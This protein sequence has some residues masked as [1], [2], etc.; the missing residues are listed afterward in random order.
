MLT[1]AGAFTKGVLPRLGP[2]LDG[3]DV[4]REGL[5]TLVIVPGSFDMV[6]TL[7][8]GS[9]SNCIRLDFIGDLAGAIL[10]AAALLAITDSC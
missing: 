5:G 9:L 1:V 6:G 10:S 3:D 8:G 4:G 7:S 2:K